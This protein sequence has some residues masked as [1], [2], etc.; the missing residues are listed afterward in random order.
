MDMGEVGMH[1]SRLMCVFPVEVNTSGSPPACLSAQTTNKRLSHNLFGAVCF[2]VL[3]SSLLISLF[4]VALGVIQRPQHKRLWSA[5]C[6]SYTV[7][8]AL[9]RHEF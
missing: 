6:R 9:F 7:R 8:Y 4:K 3:H 5:L 1:L 2:T